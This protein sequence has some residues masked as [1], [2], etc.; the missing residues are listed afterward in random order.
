MFTPTFKSLSA[1]TYPVPSVP[2]AGKEEPP[3]DNTKTSASI[4]F[5]SSV[6]TTYVSFASFFVI[7]FTFVSYWNVTP[8]RLHASTS[9]SLTSLEELERGKY[10]FVVCSMPS[11]S[12]TSSRSQLKHFGTVQLCKIAFARRGLESVT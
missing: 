7:F 8:S 5:P 3:I 12:R 9:L 10:L 6:F 1:M 4:S 2:T 11:S